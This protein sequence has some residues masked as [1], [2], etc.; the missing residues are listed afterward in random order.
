MFRQR[1]A[2]RDPLRHLQPH[3]IAAT[4]LL[5][6]LAL[7]VLYSVA[8][9]IW[10]APDE[11]GHY[12]YARYIA[13]R[14]TLPQAGD[15]DAEQIQERMQPP[16]YYL[17]GALSV[18]WINISDDLRPRLNP[19]YTWGIGTGGVNYAVHPDSEAF[20]YQGTVL[21]VHVLRLLSVALSLVGIVCTYVVG[22]TIAPTR[23]EIAIGAMA[24]HAFWPQ[25][26][27]N[28]SVITNDV[29]ASAVG[30]AITLVMILMLRG[31]A[32][33]FQVLTL[34]FLFGLGLLSKLNTMALLPIAVFVVIKEAISRLRGS[35]L[36]HRLYWGWS[37]LAVGLALVVSWQVLQQM[38][39]VVVPV[40][41][42]KDGPFSRGV[43]SGLAELLAGLDLVTLQRAVSHVFRTFLGLFGWANVPMEP[44]LYDMYAVLLV[45]ALVGILLFFVRRRSEP[46]PICVAVLSGQ[47]LAMLGLCVLLVAAHGKQV[48]IAPGR[49]LLPAISA[50]SV[51]LFLGCDELSR[52]GK[53][54]PLPILLT[55]ALTSL[56]VVIPFRYIMPAYA[57]P[58]LLSPGDVY[59]LEHQVSLKFADR[60][61]LLAYELDSTEIRPRGVA[62]LTLYWRALASMDQDYTVCVRLLGPNGETAGEA[63]CTYPGRGNY[64]TSLWKVGDV[65]ADVYG[66]RL[67]RGF[68]QPGFARINVAVF[69]Y[70]EE[71]CLPVTDPQGTQVGR[72]ATFGRVKVASAEG[73]AP[74]IARHVSYNL[75]D[76]M[77][78]VGYDLVGA[79]SPGRTLTVKLYWES[80][81]PTG[82]DYTVFVHV[83]DRDGELWA[84]HDS[85]PRHNT[86][87]TSLWGEGEIIEDEHVLTLPASIP[88]GTY[89]IRVGMYLLD[90]MQRLPA[91][92]DQGRRQRDDTVVLTEVTIAPQ[93]NP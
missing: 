40:V 65:F 24:T 83:V 92:D 32:S 59:D 31:R 20:P 73:F 1:P 2:V 69:R 36:R 47:L 89:E 11:P 86:Y 16:L 45:L 42:Y 75:G 68:P 4:I 26:L 54:S 52:F 17:L 34:A 19:F 39:Q 93:A 67:S 22:L 29:L 74:D 66:L 72:S 79:P 78:L 50:F 25:F 53:V 5:I 51:L 37:V 7:G 60:I 27:F 33:V 30:S 13:I 63:D 6:R 48:W 88:A 43:V 35:D 41:G 38:P 82:E 28:G 57:R 62:Q 44:V 85:Q 70:P 14:H 3:W 91:V 56:A 55:I 46:S 12:E 15:P 87:P 9:P 23:R 81:T 18:S 77:A 21:A 71:D 64:A 61:E 90:T 10:E 8:I 58:T 84:Q 80:L 76:T 49:Y